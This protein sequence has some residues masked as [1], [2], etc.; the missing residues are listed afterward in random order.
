ME[1][2]SEEYKAELISQLEA[3]TNIVK[4]DKPIPM[5]D[6]EVAKSMEDCLGCEEIA[7]KRKKKKSKKFKV[8]D[9]VF[10]LGS[11]KGEVVDFCTESKTIDVQFDNGYLESFMLCGSLVPNT[12]IVISHF[13]YELKM[14]KIK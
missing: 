5:S 1:I 13:P 7:K 11:L 9:V 3:I 14:K 10:Y 12:P 4:T 6:Y 2:F 8:G